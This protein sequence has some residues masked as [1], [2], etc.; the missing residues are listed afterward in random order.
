M[1]VGL[2]CPPITVA[3]LADPAP[4]CAGAHTHPRTHAHTHTRT[5]AIHTHPRYTHAHTP[6]TRSRSRSHGHGHGHGHG[7]THPTR[8]PSLHWRLVVT[9]LCTH[10][11][12]YQVT[13]AAYGGMVGKALVVLA[14]TPGM[15]LQVNNTAVYDPGACACWVC[16]RPTTTHAPPPEVAVTLLHCCRHH[17]LPLPPPM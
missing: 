3:A 13:G 11:Y 2:V 16:T 15:F 5:H 6:H 7:H 10:M 17:V 12:R 1:R 4:A 9:T 14:A 8:T